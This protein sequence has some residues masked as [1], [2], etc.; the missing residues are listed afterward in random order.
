MPGTGDTIL[1]QAHEPHSGPDHVK[2]IKA[3]RPIYTMFLGHGQ[4]SEGAQRRASLTLWE[5]RPPGEG[6]ILAGFCRRN[7]SL[8]G[9]PGNT[10][11]APSRG[12]CLV[13]CLESQLR[14]QPSTWPC[15]IP[16]TWDLSTR[17][18]SCSLC[19]DLPRWGYRSLDTACPCLP[20]SR[21]ARISV[22]FWRVCSAM[23]THAWVK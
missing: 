21:L 14:G 5:V 8:P 20:S 16:L 23:Q 4:G 6:S 13:P 1:N 17:P 15:S 9:S 19:G 22:R 2:R 18:F 10:K 3:H 11:G 12:A 7:R